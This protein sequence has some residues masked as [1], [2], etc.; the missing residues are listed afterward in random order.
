MSQTLPGRMADAIR[1]GR[2]AARAGRPRAECPHDLHAT[3]PGDRVVAKAWVQS[4]DENAH[5]TVIPVDDHQPDL[6]D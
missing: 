5:V 4:W 6:D 2:E 1:D 3:D